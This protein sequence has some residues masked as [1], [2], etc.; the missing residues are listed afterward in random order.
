[1]PNP[2]L[3]NLFWE[4]GK[5]K[6][7]GLKR[8]EAYHRL[9]LQNIRDLIFYLPY[10][11]IDRRYTPA[12]TEVLNGSVITQTITVEEHKFNFSRNKRSPQ[13]IICAN[14]TGKLT[15]VYFNASLNY[16]KEKYE[17][18]KTILVSGKAEFS[19]GDLQ[20]VHPDIV[21]EP[22][23]IDKV[24]ILEPVYHTTYGL[25][26]KFLNLTIQNS[27][28]FIPALPEW[29]PQDLLDKHGWISWLGSLKHAH[30]PENE[31]EVI[32]DSKYKQRLAF[33]E[34]LASQLALSLAR[35]NY[36]KQSKAEL[37]FHGVLTKKLY[38]QLP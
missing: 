31:D 9:G 22:I 24:K 36:Q 17:I 4:V 8:A 10:Q 2:L 12:L 13:K 21:A 16:L 30:H 1:M 38:E 7:V 29:L 18:G 32:G 19:N 6:N 25:N 35:K 28:K 37:N 5:L 20:M 34:L 3:L 15:L 26:S 14:K 23:E 11:I 27:L 33:D